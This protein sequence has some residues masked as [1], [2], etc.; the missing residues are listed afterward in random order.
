[1]NHICGVLG[2][3]EVLSQMKSISNRPNFAD[4][5]ISSLPTILTTA[6]TSR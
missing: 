6:L 5:L 3:C 1:M 4:I 2:L